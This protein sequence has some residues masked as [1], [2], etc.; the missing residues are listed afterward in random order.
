ML[1]RS[2][3]LLTLTREPFAI[4]GDFLIPLAT[5]PEFL[6]QLRRRVHPTGWTRHSDFPTD[7]QMLLR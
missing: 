2:P 5:L 6:E 7:D 1:P 3:R 4:S